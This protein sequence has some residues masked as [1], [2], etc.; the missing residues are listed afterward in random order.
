MT[1][2]YDHHAY[3]YLGSVLLVHNPT[4]AWTSLAELL[5][6]SIQT[7]KN[8]HVE[9]FVRDNDDDPFSHLPSELEVMHSKN[10]IES[11]T[12]ELVLA[13]DVDCNWG[14]RWGRL[15]ELFTKTGWSALKKLSVTIRI[16]SRE[17]Q[18]PLGSELALQKLP[19][20]QFVCLLSSK[21]ISFG[22]HSWLRVG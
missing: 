5:W 6:P 10:V 20:T 19:E 13:T 4:S 18:P 16:Y 14:N 11:I 9:F 15:D 8:L 21:T 17:R 3:K 7:I 12:I 2:S 1:P 22:C